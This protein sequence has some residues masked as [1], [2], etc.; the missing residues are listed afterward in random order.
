M[1]STTLLM[2]ALLWHRN[3]CDEPAFQTS[4]GFANPGRDPVIVTVFLKGEGRPAIRINGRVAALPYQM[5]VEA[6]RWRE[7]R[8]DPVDRTGE[9]CLDPESF[10]L[11]LIIDGPLAVYG[12]V[13]DRQSGDARTVTPVDLERD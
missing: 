5:E 12:T 8:L 7:L 10:D 2:P 13:V 11:E 4:I 1:I 3:P 9:L 6:G